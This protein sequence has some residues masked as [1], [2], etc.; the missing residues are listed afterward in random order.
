MFN[1]PH[2]N[3]TLFDLIRFDLDQ[4]I[5]D[6]VS[7]SAETWFGSLTSGDSA[8]NLVRAHANLPLNDLYFDA[9][10]RWSRAQAPRRDAAV[11]TPADE[12]ANAS[13]M[14]NAGVVE[15]V[16]EW[17]PTLIFRRRP[18]LGD[19]VRAI[20]DAAEVDAADLVYDDVGRSDA[21]L[22][23]A[24]YLEGLTGPGSVQ[25]QR[26]MR[27]GDH[28]DAASVRRH[29]LR[30]RVESVNCWPNDPSLG[31]IGSLKPWLDRLFEAYRVNH[32]LLSGTVT[33]PRLLR[34]A[35]V[36]GR[37]TIRRGGA[38][39]SPHVPS[40]GEEVEDVHV[41]DATNLSWSMPSGILQH[42]LSLVR[43]HR[44]RGRGSR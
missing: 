3:S 8:M 13:A 42:T 18:L 20:P 41:I 22:V 2:I 38:V 28:A 44:A 35:W 1:V 12:V 4:S 17:A 30:V 31:Q 26:F 16:T 14:P 19:E 27:R 37:L 34:R 15:T 11:R 7:L 39:P 33:V 6:V 40:F 5:E 10:P 25:Q 32:E 21:D 36:G 9:R 29:G 24:M 23:N 43:G